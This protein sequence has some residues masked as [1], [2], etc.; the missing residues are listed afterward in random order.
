MKFAQIF[1]TVL[2]IGCIAAGIAVLGGYL[3][4]ASLIGV[5]SS[6]NQSSPWILIV[7][8]VWVLAVPYLPRLRK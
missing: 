3:D 5:P 2:A 8:G 1:I 7:T 4:A 6:F